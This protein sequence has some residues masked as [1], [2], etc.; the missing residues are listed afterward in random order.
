[1]IRTPVRAALVVAHR[2]AKSA[3]SD[4]TDLY[5]SAGVPQIELQMSPSG[6]ED[7]FA[8]AQAF[9]DADLRVTL[10]H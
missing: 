5:R 1:M 2:Y 8:V 3:T 10:R 6:G 9:T 7:G 4:F